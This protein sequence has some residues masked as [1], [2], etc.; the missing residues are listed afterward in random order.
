MNWRVIPG[1][2]DVYAWQR[3]LNWAIEWDTSAGDLVI[4]AGEPQ[5]FVKFADSHSGN[6]SPELIECKLT[7]ELEE[8]LLLSRGIT[9]IRK[10]VTPLMKR[11]GDLRNDQTL[12]NK[13]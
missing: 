5:Y 4:R 2:F 9:G 3:P 8:R 6:C 11:A 7:P 13:N 12:I 10:G 1:K